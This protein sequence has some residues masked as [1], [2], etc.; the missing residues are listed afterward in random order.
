[1]AEVLRDFPQLRDIGRMT[2]Q[3]GFATVPL[4]LWDAKTNRLVSFREADRLIKTRERP[5][6]DAGRGRSGH[7]QLG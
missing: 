5:H 1:M 2:L 6:A 3:G 7:G 4:T